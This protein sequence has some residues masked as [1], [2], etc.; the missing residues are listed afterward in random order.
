MGYN[1]TVFILNDGFDQIQKYPEEFVMGINRHM[2]DGA[3]FGV[4][5]HCNSVTVMRSQHADVPRLYFTHQ[6]WISELSE[7]NEETI[8]Y[9]RE[10]NFR[11]ELIRDRIAAAR[12]ILDRL[13]AKA[14]Q[15]D[16]EAQS[17]PPTTSGN[18]PPS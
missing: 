4:G 1:T 12:Q 10:Q 5:N 8:S 16:A 7:Y 18:I 13:E 14:D 17:P 9:L 11:T 3:D 15:I 2:H 6:N